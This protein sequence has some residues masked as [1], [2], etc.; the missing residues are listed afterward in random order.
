MKKLFKGINILSRRNLIGMSVFT[1]GSVF[2]GF[3]FFK[4]KGKIAQFNPEMRSPGS[5]DLINIDFDNLIFV[6]GRLPKETSGFARFVQWI[7]RVRFRE[8]QSRGHNTRMFSDI[9]EYA[10]SGKLNLKAWDLDDILETNLKEKEKNTKNFYIRTETPNLLDFEIKNNK[11][12]L[13]ARS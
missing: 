6:N 5:T 4:S 11:I 8:K 2:S 13:N 10:P 3:L 9:S 12:D 1:L 7:G